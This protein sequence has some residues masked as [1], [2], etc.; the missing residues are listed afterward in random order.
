MEKDALAAVVQQG[1]A[2][3]GDAEEVKEGGRGRG[4]KRKDEKEEDTLGFITKQLK[5]VQDK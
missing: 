3:G 2:R 1:R 5:E 4:G